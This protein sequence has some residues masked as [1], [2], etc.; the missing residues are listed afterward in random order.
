MKHLVAIKG[1]QWES[2]AKRETIELVTFYLKSA[3]WAPDL[4][5]VKRF[6]YTT[7]RDKAA[8]LSERKARLVVEQLRS[9][10]RIDASWEA[11]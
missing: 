1:T 9:N 3:S 2:R 6:S 10:A 5:T 4:R 8:R 7:N 11:V